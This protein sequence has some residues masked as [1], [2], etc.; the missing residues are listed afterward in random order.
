MFAIP[1][2]AR[3]QAPIEILDNGSCWLQQIQEGQQNLGFRIASFGSG[4][5]FTL[6]AD[7]FIGPEAQLKAWVQSQLKARFPTLPALKYE[8]AL[9]CYSAG[10][11]ISVQIDRPDA[12]PV[13][14][15]AKAKATNA[16]NDLELTALHPGDYFNEGSVCLGIEERQV[17][18][19]LK[20]S[21]EIEVQSLRD[22]I[23]KNPALSEV[24]DKIEYRS[25]SFFA[26]AH[27]KE[28][29]SF[30]EVEAKAKLE[31]NAEVMNFVSNLW[32]NS[33]NTITGEDRALFQGITD[34]Y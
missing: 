6:L 31:A 10:H 28:A 30:R 8:V 13:C 33:F 23:A 22:A 27:L 11:F 14:L 12:Q 16:V 5:A 15:N 19:S 24:V 32:L 29:Y 1:M 26:I 4:T 7:P 34:A 20:K 9:H 17:G 21:E 3:A 2:S 25:G 18:L